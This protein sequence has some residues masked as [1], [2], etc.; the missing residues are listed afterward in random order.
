MRSSTWV[1]LVVVVVAA[2]APSPSDAFRDQPEA[3]S[4]TAQ[5]TY[6][7]SLEEFDI[8]DQPQHNTTYRRELEI[9][10]IFKGVAYGA[11][12]TAEPDELDIRSTTEKLNSHNKFQETT[13][14]M[15]KQQYIVNHVSSEEYLHTNDVKDINE[16]DELFTESAGIINLVSDSPPES[17]YP[18]FLINTGHNIS[19]ITLIA[20]NLDYTSLSIRYSLG[21]AWWIH[22]YV[23]AGL[24]ALLSFTAICC[25]VCLA[26]SPQL[27]LHGIYLTIDILIF[28]AAFSRCLHLSHDSSDIL[29]APVSTLVIETVWPCL[30]TAVAVMIIAVVRTWQ[31]HYIS[32]VIAFLSITHLV[33]TLLVHMFSVILTQHAIYLMVIARAV[34]AAWSISIGIFGLWGLWRSRHDSYNIPSPVF[35][36]IMAVIAQ[37]FLAFLHIYIMMAPVSAEKHIWLWLTLISLARSLELLIGATLMVSAAFNLSQPSYLRTSCQ[38][39]FTS[40]CQKSTVEFVHPSEV[41]MIHPLGVYTL[42]PSKPKN[43]HAQT[44]AA[45]TLKNSQRETKDQSSLDYV[46]SD[47][48]LVWNQGRQMPIQTSQPS[49]RL[50]ST[51]GFLH[52][53][54]DK[55]SDPNDYTENNSSSDFKNDPI[56]NNYAFSHTMPYNRFYAN[57]GG[58]SNVEENNHTVFASLSHGYNMSSQIYDQSIGVSSSNSSKLYASPQ[59]LMRTSRSWDE[60]SSGPIYEDLQKIKG[61]C[62]SDE[63]KRNSSE[64]ITDYQN[65]LSHSL[66]DILGQGRHRQHKHR[67]SKRYGPTK[68]STLQ[69]HPHKRSPNHPDSSHISL[70][71][72]QCTP[73]NLPLPRTRTPSLVSHQSSRTPLSSATTPSQA[74]TSTER[75]PTQAQQTCPRST[76]FSSKSFDDAFDDIINNFPSL[77]SRKS[78]DDT[79]YSHPN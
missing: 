71:R 59:S 57:L 46:T 48:Q 73:T 6:Q 39:F 64:Q 9:A 70:H 66:D 55:E 58:N 45:L 27:F 49:T 17:G 72:S 28:I 20:G 63:S 13:K 18:I 29:P 2:L 62:S 10:A 12:S 56:V 41:K 51:N 8:Y 3:S 44:I 47:F 37:L 33:A 75:T 25:L 43:E 61:L 31:C 68:S 26:T 30:T 35:V 15:V 14:E 7:D 32:M 11:S 22:V 65:E 42:Q 5:D 21:V 53:R 76:S 67:G 40:C 4:M 60:L 79:L 19:G 50:I 69:R 23:S 74:S 24:F 52:F 34:T 38:D 78:F 16:Y 36:V 54:N 77:Y 1:P